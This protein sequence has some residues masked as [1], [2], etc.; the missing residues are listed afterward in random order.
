MSEVSNAVRAAVEAAQTLPPVSEKGPQRAPVKIM[1]AVPAYTGQLS[2]QFVESFVAAFALCFVNGIE[3][4]LEVA[5]GFSLV[6]YARNFL[7]AKFLKGDFTHL[8][9]IDSDLGFD[10][11]AI[12]RMLNRN[13][14]VIL[15]AYPTK[16]RQMMFHVQLLGPP[17]ATG[18]AEIDRGPGGFCLMSQYAVA[19]VSE[20]VRK[21]KM[22]RD[23]VDYKVPNVFDMVHEGETLWGEDFVFHKRLRR[24]GFS[25]YIET[26]LVFTHVG[27]NQWQGNF[28]DAIRSGAISEAQMPREQA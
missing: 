9:W 22:S 6:H 2:F 23:G 8:L 13:V 17:D 21:H 5:P 28:A 26:D 20:S 25:I 7:V 27:M 18:L 16:E 14:D 10:P 24:L 19:T 15:G 4:H 3:L 11:R 12:P 1:V